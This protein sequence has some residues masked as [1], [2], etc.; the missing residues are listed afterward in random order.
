M[1]FTLPAM[2]LDTRMFERGA[3]IGSVIRLIFT[4]AAACIHLLADALQEPLYSALYH[5]LRHFHSVSTIIPIVPVFTTVVARLRER[6]LSLNTGR[7]STFNAL[8][9]QPST[10]NFLL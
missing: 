1:A 8:E 4:A 2:Y 6:P 5:R 3:R 9:I 10:P 7:F